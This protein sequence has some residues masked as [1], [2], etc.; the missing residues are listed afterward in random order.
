M[1][2]KT[3][4][5]IEDAREL[6]YPPYHIGFKR[7]RSYCRI[8]QRCSTIPYDTTFNDSG[9]LYYVYYANSEELAILKAVA[10]QAAEALE[11]GP[12]ED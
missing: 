1:N 9:S 10:V 11:S 12:A 8:L 4:K 3:I 2:Q 7:G 6:L 5:A